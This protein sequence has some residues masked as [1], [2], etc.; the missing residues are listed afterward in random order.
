MTGIALRN[1]TTSDTGV[2]P[3]Q[4]WVGDVLSTASS[5]HPAAEAQSTQADPFII[6][7]L[8]NFRRV[9]NSLRI[10]LCS[11]GYTEFFNL[12]DMSSAAFSPD[13]PARSTFQAYRT[14]ILS[15]RDAAIQEGD[16]LN[17]AS[18][19]YFWHFVSSNPLLRRGNLVLVDN[20]N[21][22]AV[23]KDGQGTHLGMQ[24]L[25][26]GM[27]QYVIFKQRVAGLPPSRVAGRDTA[28]GIWRQISAFDLTS[29]I[30]Q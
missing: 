11:A 21:L 2:L 12:E 7:K 8:E 9:D 20:G 3:L 23:W 14:R 30:Y 26:D 29:L 15:L 13:G 25:D 1:S 28:D 24:F 5:L 22:R 16:C 17:Y 19:Y 27:I 18:E 6:K 10:G 4:S